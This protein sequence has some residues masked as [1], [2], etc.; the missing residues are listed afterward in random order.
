MR[1]STLVFIFFGVI[2][3]ALAGANFFAA[4]QPPIT[5]R[6][7]VDPLAEAWVRQAAQ[8]FNAQN[9]TISGGTRVLIDVTRQT[10]AEVLAWTPST[11]RNGW[12]A[13][14]RLFETSFTPA[15]P[16]R[17]LADSLAET[18]LVW[19]GW[20]NYTSIITQDG[21]QPFDWAAVQAAAQAETWQAISAG[22]LSGNV[23]VGIPPISTSAGYGALLS[24]MASQQGAAS[25]SRAS[26]SSTAFTAWFKP[27]K[28]AIG[29]PSASIISTLS[30]QGATRINFALLTEA[31]W[32]N[33][34]STFG[35]R[36][37][38][39]Y[40]AYNVRLDFPFY[41]W[42]DASTTTQQRQ[43]LSAFANF[44][45]S[46]EQQR[47][48]AA[49]G[50]RPSTGQV[51]ARAALFAQGAPYGLLAQLPPMTF[52]SPPDRATAEAVARLLN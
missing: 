34:L 3:A 43:G 17:P 35:P 12:I 30:S 21:A 14:S 5:L 29:R 11:R 8:A 22:G 38:Y 16:F 48:L 40:P 20:G 45:M 25:I 51:D 52:I 4:N 1:R 32:L 46:A 50:L 7:A 2:F 18:V 37:D 10:E 24:A 19:G 15:Q 39:A 31:E 13:S 27:L 26:T 6:L 44:L 33:N 49:F 36:L 41:L 42:D 47:Q 28:L 9:V 23:Q